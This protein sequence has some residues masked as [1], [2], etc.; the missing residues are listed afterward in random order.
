MKIIFYT[1]QKMREKK[2]ARAFAN[3]A[4][5][6]G[7][8]IEIRRNN[9]LIFEGD[10]ACMVGVKSA[11]IWQ[12]LRKA[13][14]NAMLFD[15]GYSRHKKEGCWEY[16][17]VSL[18]AHSPTETTLMKYSYPSD[19][20]INSGFRLRDWRRRGKHILFAG[21]SAK[22]HKFF[23]LPHPTEYAK[24]IVDHLRIFTDRKII[25]RPKPSWREATKISDT[26][27]SPS[28]QSLQE[29]L[30]G[31]HTV[32]THGSNTCFESTLAGVPCIILGPGVVGPISSRHI[33]DIENPKCG[34]REKLFNALFYHQWSLAEFYSG[35]AFETINRWFDDEN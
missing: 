4:K 2:L 22:Y 9:D 12:T 33:S 21:S 19:R 28:K 3:G 24:T 16:W 10:L 6:H 31:C 18:N 11:S 23:E 14:I 27:Y 20:F 30:A 17:R 1:S 25:Y 8:E 7:H 32:V 35:Q 29:V 13:G 26:L 5:I 15:K 34:D